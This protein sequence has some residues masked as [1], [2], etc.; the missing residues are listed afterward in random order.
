MSNYNYL[1]TAGHDKTI[2][3]YNVGLKFLQVN[4]I[5]GCHSAP[6]NCLAALDEDKIVT[7]SA[8]HK[9]RL[10]SLGGTSIVKPEREF[11]QKDSGVK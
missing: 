11:D 4:N 8:D 1:V 2:R 9:I 3:V 5:S 6:I 10:F 7:G